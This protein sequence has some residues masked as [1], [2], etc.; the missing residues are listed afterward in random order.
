MNLSTE[1]RGIELAKKVIRWT[2]MP[3]N[4]DNE[5][6]GDFEYLAEDVVPYAHELIKQTRK[7]KRFYKSCKN[8]YEIITGRHQHAC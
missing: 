2:N 5:W 7:T 3:P 8:R 1:E 6:N 4:G